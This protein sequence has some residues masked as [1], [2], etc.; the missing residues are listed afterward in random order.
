MKRKK[1]FSFNFFQGSV[2]NWRFPPCCRGA[3]P[4][5]DEDED[6]C[7]DTA[8][9]DC[10]KAT[11]KLRHISAKHSITILPIPPIP[12]DNSPNLYPPSNQVE[13]WNIFVV[14]SDKTYILANVNDPFTK[15]PNNDV[16]LNHKAENIIPPDMQ[17]FF[18]AVWDQTLKNT[19][20]QLYVAWNDRLFHVN[21]YP[22]VNDTD[23]VVGATMFMRAFNHANYEPGEAVLEKMEKQRK[24]YEA[25]TQKQ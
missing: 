12:N 19:K 5:D 6:E 7:D 18:D 9:R 1:M 13:T 22:L 23:V 3:L 10:K 25:R 14:G 24:S 8:T 11:E 2:C 21:T 15:V 20:L 4:L 16:L 17:E